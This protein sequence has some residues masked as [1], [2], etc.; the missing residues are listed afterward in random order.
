MNNQ[1]QYFVK[2]RRKI[3]ILFI[4]AKIFKKV[5]INVIK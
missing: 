1:K 2:I 3:Q 5:T 4:D